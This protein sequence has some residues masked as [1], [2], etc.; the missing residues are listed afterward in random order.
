[1]KHIICIV[2]KTGRGK[3]TLARQITS[4]MGIKQICSYTT[5]PMRDCE[6]DGREHYFISDE[7][8]DDIL[9]KE[10]ILALACKSNGVRYFSTLESF[11]EDKII[12]IIDPEGIYWM[13][14]NV[15]EKDLADLFIVELYADDKDIEPRIKARGDDWD[16]YTI[17]IENEKQE[18]EDF[19]KSN[20]YNI[21]INAMLT[22]D[23]VY[24]EFSNAYNKWCIETLSKR[25][26]DDEDNN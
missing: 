19:H 6:M 8:A 15:A 13:K 14:K 23:E 2:A 12:Y 9:K 18:F 24:E 10:T 25:W 4:K 17:R 1:M 3:D 5:R 21:S 26:E 16:A 11:S 20:E 7:M 22:P